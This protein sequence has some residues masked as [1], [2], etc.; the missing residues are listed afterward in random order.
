MSGASSVFFKQGTSV[1]LAKDTSHTGM[2]E[3]RAK[4]AMITS[5]SF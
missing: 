2:K 1:L 5:A 3:I 4:T